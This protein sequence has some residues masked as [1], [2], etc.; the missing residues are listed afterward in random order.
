MRRARK[1]GTRIIAVRPLTRAKTECDRTSSVVGSTSLKKVSTRHGFQVRAGGEIAFIN[2]IL[3]TLIA[4]DQI[5]LEFIG[6]HTARF[7]EFREALQT[8]SWKMLEQCSGVSRT[9]MQLA[10]TWRTLRACPG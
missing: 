8:Q 10:A 4:N 1:A 3:K 5:D 6:K 2:G 7:R 9:A